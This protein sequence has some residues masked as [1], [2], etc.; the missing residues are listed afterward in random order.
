MRRAGLVIFALWAMPAAGQT[1]VTS[2]GPERVALTVY[3]DPARPAE[4]AMDT[5]DGLNGYALV[6][7]TRT[8]ALPAG[9]TT[10]RFE[11]VAGGIIPE[12][13]IVSGLPAGVVEKNQDA[14]LLSPASLLD[15]SFGR[16]VHLRRTSRATGQTREEEVVI[17]TG[18]DGG[19]VLQT[20]AGFEALRC[21]GLPETLVYDAIPDGLTARPT[22]SVR[23]DSVRAATATVI[24]SYLAIGFDWQA[25]YV[26]TLAPGGKRMDLFAWMTLA[27]GD[28]TS[29]RDAETQA[30]AGKVN[31]EADDGGDRPQGASLRLQ[32]WQAPGGYPPAAPVYAPMAM[33]YGDEGGEEIVVTG[34][35]IRYAAVLEELG[36]LKLYRIPAAV[37]V[38][39]M[40]RKQVALLERKNVPVDLIYRARVTAAA[41]D[42]PTPATR[43]YRARNRSDGGLGL[44]LPA[45]RVTFFTARARRPLLI[46]EGFVE[47]RAIGED[48][49]VEAG[50]APGV[51]Y[52]VVETGRSDDKD[53]VRLR[54]IVTNDAPAPVDFEAVMMVYEGRRL[55]PTARL[56][57]KNG[58]PIWISRIP[59][60]G[61]RSMDFA[62]VEDAATEHDDD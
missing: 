59:A 15:R 36:D 47:D 23:V 38:A 40:S 16:R 26:A 54:L 28:E 22:L 32:C 8:I 31:R 11:G 45:G 37:T 30:V 46:G 14:D 3:R 4:R 21:S 51:R 48:V 62:V 5:D 25:D 19:V 33:A 2:T 42:E 61:R 41:R 6:S 60:N 53:E 55:A 57:T 34:S 12:S 58:R 50:E 20:A 56:S 1:V 9:A 43:V 39:A 35:R 10:I 18:A 17:R 13:A 49:E 24:L 44:P 27:N 29:F 52:Q 7:E